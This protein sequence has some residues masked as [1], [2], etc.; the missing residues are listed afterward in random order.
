[1]NSLLGKSFQK[2]I[3]E[4][5]DVVE[6]MQA[7]RPAAQQPKRQSQAERDA[8]IVAALMARIAAGKPA[9]EPA[10]TVNPF[11]EL[12]DEEIERMQR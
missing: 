5:A 1:M 6:L 4:G 11:V 7:T 2:E 3:A 10:K 9:P 8:E 12:S